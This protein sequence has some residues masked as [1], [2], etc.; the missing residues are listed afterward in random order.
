MNF[1]KY[2]SGFKLKWISAVRNY[3]CGRAS[4]GCLFGVKVNSPWYKK[5]KFLE[6]DGIVYLYVMVE[7]KSLYIVPMYINSNNWM[8]EYNAVY[9]FL[10]SLDV[11]DVMLVGDLNARVGSEQV[12]L[13]NSYIKV[14][15]NETRRAKDLILNSRGLQMLEL[16]QNFNMYIVNGVSRSDDKGEFTFVS[17][18][19]SSIIDLCCIAGEWLNYVQDFEVCPITYSEHL[20]I[21]IFVDLKKDQEIQREKYMQIL[22]RLTWNGS[23]AKDYKQKLDTIL[24][25]R[26]ETNDNII[27]DLVG[28]IGEAAKVLRV[29][30]RKVNKLNKQKWF[31][32]E[33]LQARS[34]SFEM[35]QVFRVTQSEIDRHLYVKSNRSF[36]IICNNKKKEYYSRMAHNFNS[37]RDSSQFWKLA[38]E[39]N[40]DSVFGR[41]IQT[42][43]VTE[44]SEYFSKLLNPE[45]LA[46]P[47]SYAEPSIS[48]DILDR[49]ITY[50]ELSLVL[51]KAKNKKAPG[52]DGIPYEFF[53][54]APD[55]FINSLLRAYNECFESGSLPE[56]FNKAIIYPLHKKGD[57][58]NVANYRGISF[59]NAVAKIFAGILL[60]RLEL[61]VSENN[62]L[63]ENQ[64]GFRKGYST[65]DSI[66]VLKNVVEMN[67]LQHKKVYGFFIDFSAAF[68]SI[69]RDSL[70]YKLNNI[71][72][73][74]K[75]LKILKALYNNTMSAVWSGQDL[76]DWFY[77]KSGVKQGC[78]LSP[79][80]FALFIDDIGDCVVDGIRVGDIILKLLLYADDIVIFAY[81][82]RQLQQ[83]INKIAE[84]CKLWSLKINLQ[85][86]K[87]MVF[88]NGGRLSVKEKWFF[89]QQP[90]EVVQQ[91]K[92][93]GFVLTTKLS[94]TTQLKEKLAAGK[95]AINTTW[96]NLLMKKNVAHSAKYSVFES[97]IKSI[98]CYAG[99]VWGY[100]KYEE[101]EKILR[102]FLKKLFKLPVTTPNYMLHLETGLAPIYL[103]TL[104]QHFDYILKV[105]Q[106]NANGRLTLRVAKYII[107]SKTL[108]FK[109]WNILANTLNL[110]L[111]FN[112][113][114]I[115]KENLYSLLVKVDS[116]QWLDF[117]DQARA[118]ERRNIYKNLSFVGAQKYNYFRDSNSTRKI[119][120][121]FRTRGELLPLN[122]KPGVQ[123]DLIICS[124][125]NLHEREDVLHFVGVCPI[126]SEIRNFIF[127]KSR[128]T[129]QEV[130]SLLQGG[131]IE[132]NSIY[133]Y[134]Q[135][136]LSYREKIISENF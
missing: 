34:K 129:P 57:V 93:L 68:D 109:Q 52:I 24:T 85:K 56:S 100:Y 25:A 35:L 70:W 47:V 95:C 71:G 37:A 39:L 60:S 89:N 18:Q 136:A 99:Q 12:L 120:L 63:S 30:D 10:M 54:N 4:G 107:N 76:S 131:E 32:K 2:F 20:P 51:G 96:R 6:K 38:R 102:F 134:V 78:L 9:N 77:T 75:F 83:S 58:N 61:F 66:F 115:N 130:C 31:D 62:I 42:I 74:S 44:L 126:L 105:L 128:L 116:R 92:Y 19:G 22:P 65:V 73:S 46:N 124:L 103:Y 108:W 132:I 36:K 98:V 104:K 33:C 135:L 45:I 94:L 111:I 133:R 119:S 97:V 17:K 48:N 67:L 118:S 49:P 122:Y 1:E 11:G 64:F 79:L 88:R 125:C 15:F 7:G 112:E 101:V 28:M 40:N 8:N 81:S 69:D 127:N 50:M 41:N 21:K 27:D 121:I 29:S 86:S 106:G 16:L 113:T 91:Y 23:V 14:D 43:P 84:Y 5:A 114:N 117:V 26:R 123:E 110:G 3:K 13:N 53:K 80:L 72:V 87:I 59:S 82:V 55:T 90:I